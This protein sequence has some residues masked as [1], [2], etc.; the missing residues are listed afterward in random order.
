MSRDKIL[1][2]EDDNN[3]REAISTF[4]E[5]NDLECLTAANGKEGLMC[6]T[7][8]PV[9]MVICDIMLPD[10]LGWEIL[11]A[12]RN[13]P[14]I[15]NI[16]FIFLSAYADKRDVHKGLE[17]GA[18]EYVTK[19]F[20]NKELIETIFFWLKKAKKDDNLFSQDVNSKVLN[21]LSKNLALEIISPLDGLVNGGNFIG[22][23]PQSLRLSDLPKDMKIGDLQDS[24]I[25]MYASGIRLQRDL[26]N[27]MAL[28]AL[29]YNSNK[30]LH[31]GLLNNETDLGEILDEKVWTYN[32]I[33][34]RECLI[35]DLHAVP[36]WRGSKKY[37][38][39]IFGELIDNA[40]KF[41]RGDKAPQLILKPVADSG[42]IFRISNGVY[43]DLDFNV[44]NIAPYKKFHEDMSI[45]GLGL[46]LYVGK[47]LCEL[48]GYDFSAEIK[49]GQFTVTVASR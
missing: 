5:V 13:D 45:S 21:L 39:I 25:T 26:Q 48:F 49:N 43:E 17:M 29:M 24:F 15:Y 33:Y 30:E 46:G 4:I 2:I 28:S 42:F 11:K 16:P 35:T 6:L 36:Y 19:P 27:Y 32:K 37:I 38:A 8:G 14:R 18:D 31:F 23:Q 3:L 9:D 44:V 47:S 40:L 34:R 20:S 7:A 22:S 10:I 12:V 41:N 1:V